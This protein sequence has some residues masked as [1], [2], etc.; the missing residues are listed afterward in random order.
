MRAV[1]VD[2]HNLVR[3]GM[4]RVLETISARLEIVGEAGNGRDALR[5][6]SELEVDL[7]ITDLSMPD[8]DG[9]SLIKKARNRRPGIKCVVLSMHTEQ[10]HVVAALRAGA[11]GYVHKDAS[12][13]ELSLALE[14]IGKGG[15]YVH[16]AVAGAV[17]DLLRASDERAEPLD[18]L[19][20]RQR[21]ILKL[22]A[23]GCGTRE[24]ADRLNVSIKTVET[25]RAQLM[26]RLN[27]RNVPGLVKFAVRHGLVDVESD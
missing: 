5:L 8:T 24:I 11:C 2:D 4:R 21:E 15:S 7:L 25:H 16:P 13:E 18:L 10:K 26:G 1:I 27:I 9:I 23:E 6:L 17:I 19:T 20:D 12:T 22:I 14:S 3:T